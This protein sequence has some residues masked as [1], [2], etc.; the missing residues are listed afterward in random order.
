M[1]TVDPSLARYR[2]IR[3]QFNKLPADRDG[4]RMNTQFMPVDELKGNISLGSRTDSDPD[5]HDILSFTSEQRKG[6]SRAETFVEMPAPRGGWFGRKKGNETLVHLSRQVSHLPGGYGLSE[7]ALRTVDLVTGDLVSEVKG[8]KAIKAAQ[9][10]EKD[11]PFRIHY[12]DPAGH[13][14]P[15]ENWLIS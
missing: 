13:E 14:R 10:L 3:N 1:T 12:N 15:E 6:G 2:T 9:K 11:I 4:M 8:D 5:T 7:V